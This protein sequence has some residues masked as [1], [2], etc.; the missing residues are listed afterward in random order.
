MPQRLLLRSLTGGAVLMAAFAGSS[1]RPAQ[2]NCAAPCSYLLCHGTN[3][4]LIEGHTDDKGANLTVDGILR[5]GSLAVVVGQK[6]A[7]PRMAQASRAVVAQVDTGT[8]ASAAPD[9]TVFY[10]AEAGGALSCDNG[11]GLLEGPSHGGG[12]TAKTLAEALNAGETACLVRARAAGYPYPSCNDTPSAG[13]CTLAPR[14]AGGAPGLATLGLA[15]AALI[16]GLRRWRMRRL[17]P[18]ARGGAPAGR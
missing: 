7:L 15:A 9:L 6:I 2:A 12:F 4:T 8:E 14:P 10:P 1:V 11:T 13:G 3:P 18:V 17:Q 16:L 5:V